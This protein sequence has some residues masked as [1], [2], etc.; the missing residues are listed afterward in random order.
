MFQR[1]LVAVDGSDQAHAALKIAC[2]VAEQSAAKLILVCV[3]NTDI[4]EDVVDAAINEGIVRPSDYQAFA[5][6]LDFPEISSAR[7]QA[8]RDAILSRTATV[9]A[10]EIS[11]T[12]KTSPRTTT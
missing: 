7:T 12:K 6:T 9:I 10:Q 8:T 11:R 3:T 2:S 4:P 1:I 5:G